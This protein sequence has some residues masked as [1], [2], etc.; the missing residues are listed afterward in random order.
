MK[1]IYTAMFTCMDDGFELYARI[2]DLPGCVA[3]GEDLDDA[4][5]QI[6]LA[7]GHWLAAAEAEGRRIP[8]PSAQADLS[9]DH[10]ATLTLIRVDT[11]QYRG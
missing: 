6:T 4:I 8:P 5:D 11:D 9:A 10:G 1:Y 2:P 7:A 3:T